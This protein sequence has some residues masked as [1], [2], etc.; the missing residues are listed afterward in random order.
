MLEASRT[1]KRIFCRATVMAAV[2]LGIVAALAG[3]AYASSVDESI[4]DASSPTGSVTLAPGATATI[5]IDLSVTGRQLG[6]ATFEV[7]TAWT[8]SG[9]T[10]TGTNPQTFTVP[11]R[12][13]S[14]PATTF[15]TSGTVTVD[16]GQSD[17]AFTL[18][19]GAFAITNSN[20]TG[21]KLGPGN[22]SDYEVTVETPK[23]SDT[24][25]P[26][27]GYHFD[28]PTPDGDNGWY[29]SEVSLVW[30]VTEDES[31][32]SLVK[33][34]CVDQNV[35]AD[36]TEV[37]YSC[38]ATS[39]GGSAGPV[40][41]KIKRDGTA[42]GVT[43]NGGPEDGAS[44]YFGSVP[45][46][47]TCDATDSL[48]G[49]DDCV[50][51]G[52]LTTVGP[53]TLT[54]TAHDLAGNEKTEERSYTVLAWTLS[55]FYRPTRMDGVFNVVKGGSTVPLKF[56]VFAGPTELTDT[57]DVTSLTAAKANCDGSEPTDEVA[58]TAS[59]NTTLRYDPTAGQFV[60]NWQTP[61]TPGLCYRVTMTT[62]DASTLVAYFKL[63]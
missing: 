47:A 16:S 18:Q 10:F 60:Y 13:A 26:S 40:E 6:T 15:H 44:Y 31:P 61:S 1:T 30:T 7:N 5:A 4:V 34:G 41:A 8:L 17:G 25:P 55:G 50:V 32:L 62:Q 14:D 35:T 19:V 21:A 51:S 29:R 24:T 43:W 59:G 36:Q 9:G 56:E 38:S 23:P 37:T 27:I 48:S 53:H 3:G 52:Y 12:A 49:P 11:P 63:K 42:P 54:A 33:T 22:L 20:S 45:P 2:V 39:D 58:T 28:P 57:A 46:A